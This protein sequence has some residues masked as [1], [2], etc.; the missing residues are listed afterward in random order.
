MHRIVRT[1]IAECLTRRFHSVDSTTL[2]HDM[3]VHTRVCQTINLLLFFA[4]H[5]SQNLCTPL[6]ALGLPDSSVQNF[7]LENDPVP[8]ALLTADP[9]FHALV[10]RREQRS[11]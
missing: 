11:A 10:G 9:A 6:Q 8:R 5:L 7:V 2:T 1:V 4:Q 3:C